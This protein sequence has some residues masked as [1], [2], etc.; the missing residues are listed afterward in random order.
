MVG[1]AV[2]VLRLMGPP[3]RMPCSV[4]RMIG[5]G[6]GAG[7]AMRRGG[8]GGD[9]GGGGRGLGGEGGGGGA[10]SGGGEGGGEPSVPQE[11]EIRSG[12]APAPRH[13]RVEAGW[14]EGERLAR[15]TATMAKQWGRS[16]D[17]WISGGRR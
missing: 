14:R 1:R 8:G 3:P 16:S 11:N 2:R 10:G 4:T 7:G 12:R 5:G 15:Q 17:G 13:T 9:G 6:G